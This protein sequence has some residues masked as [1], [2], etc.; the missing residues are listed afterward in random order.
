MK[1]QPENGNLLLSAAAFY[2]EQD[3]VAIYDSST[4]AYDPVGK[5]VSQGLELEARANLNEN[6]S[7][8]ASYTYTDAAYD[9]PGDTKDGKQPMQVPEHMASLWGNYSFYSGALNGLSIGA[10]ARFVGEMAANETN[11]ITVPDYTIFDLSLNY[12]M[13]KVGLENTD[14]RV[15]VNNLLDEEYVASCLI[16][17]S[18]DNCYYGEESLRPC[19]IGSDQHYFPIKG[20]SI[21]LRPF[22]FQSDDYIRQQREAQTRQ[23]RL[24]P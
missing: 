17:S 16:T 18:S 13:A 8:M 23:A 4:Y 14:L 15:N 19:A 1:Y 22:A 24:M 20:R 5:I 9:A 21:V 12:D 7:V 2:L 6:L 10:G 11:T 3:N